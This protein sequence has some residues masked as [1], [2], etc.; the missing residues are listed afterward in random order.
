LEKNK[1]LLIIPAY[2]EEATIRE[3]VLRVEKYVD[4]CIVDDHSTDKTPKILKDIPAIHVITHK[5]NTHIPRTVMDGMKYAIAQN[6]AYAITMDAG[7]SHDP[8][9]IPR[10]LKAPESDLVIGTRTQKIET[11]LYRKMLSLI[12]NLIYNISL[13][14]PRSVFKKSYYRDIT[15]GYRRYSQKAMKSILNHPMKSRSFDFLVE[16]ASVIYQNHLSIDEVPIT[17]RFTN[18]SLK[19]QV[20][21]DCLHMCWKLILRK[22]YF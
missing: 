19:P 4:I 16:S 1:T 6:Y 18:S 8:D 12:G 21:K 22:R 7:L 10:F 11:P 20:V 2:N 15:S 13:D 5:A 3:L 9:E 14:F 17:Y